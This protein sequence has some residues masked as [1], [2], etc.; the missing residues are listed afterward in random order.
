MR[1]VSQIVYLIVLLV[2][3]AGIGLPQ[4]EADHGH[5]CVG[6]RRRDDN[7]IGGDLLDRIRRTGCG[8]RRRDGL[9]NK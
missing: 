2:I 7:A 6:R 3:I 5:P 8:R 1:I 4:I 9:E